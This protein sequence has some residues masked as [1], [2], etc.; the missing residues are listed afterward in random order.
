MGWFAG[1]L[2]ALDVVKTA[3]TDRPSLADL[4]TS[5]K[6]LFCDGFPCWLTGGSGIAPSAGSDPISPC[7]WM[8]WYCGVCPSPRVAGSPILWATCPGMYSGIVV[9]VGF[10]TTCAGTGG[11]CMAADRGT[12]LGVDAGCEGMSHSE[13][14][15][16]RRCL[17]RSC[18][19]MSHC[20]SPK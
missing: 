5:L 12:A 18:G 14:R 9:R 15:G 6:G 19:C 3:R 2:P 7:G 8:N 17:R 20:E 13:S 16:R 4:S 11:R 10:R 1:S